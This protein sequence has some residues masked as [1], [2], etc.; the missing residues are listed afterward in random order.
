MTG[1]TETER[2]RRVIDK[3]APK[4]DR[5]MNF[6][7]RLMFAGG[8]EWVCAR[9]HGRVLEIAVGT[10]RNLPYYGE[11]AELT[12]IE[13]SPEMLAIAKQ[14]AR[15]LDRRVDLRL[16][17]AQSLEFENHS[18]DTV[19]CT[20]G[21]CTIPN[22]AKAVGEAH[23]ILKPG[24]R[25]VLLEHVRSPM[26][27]VRAMQRLIEPLALRLDADHITREPIEHLTASGFKIE[28]LERSKLGIVERVA[29]RKPA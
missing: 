7:E 19:V 20:L 22:D 10:G 4:Y 16:G 28:E 29:A 14:R 27:A 17:D 24:G 12:G 15:E 2:V 11:D 5:Q 6:V 1:S 8:R 21:L 3:Q 25:F 9:A 18:F 23:R 26:V 13:L